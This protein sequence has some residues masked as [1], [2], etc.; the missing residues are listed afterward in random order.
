M[1]L[2]WEQSFVSEA[3]SWGDEL[4]FTSRS[5]QVVGLKCRRCVFNGTVLCLIFGLIFDVG[6]M[7]S[8]EISALV[9]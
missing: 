3:R 2:S 1:V 6:L 7:L 4:S 9:L 8:Y 5:V